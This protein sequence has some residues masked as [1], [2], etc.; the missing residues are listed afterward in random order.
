MHAYPADR[1]LDI[2]EAYERLDRY[3]RQ[4]GRL[5][6][7]LLDVPADTPAHRALMAAVA[8]R[9]PAVFAAAA[10]SAADAFQHILDVAPEDLDTAAGVSSIEHLRRYLFDPSPPAGIADQRL[11]LFSAPGEGLE[12]V[13]IARR[14]LGRELPRL[15]D[16][17]RTLTAARF[18]VDAA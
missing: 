9:A 11:E 3:G 14:Q 16:I 10:A 13:E 5:P 6:L 15:Y 8:A 4:Y 17:I 7:L 1:L 18:Q 12:A 2:D